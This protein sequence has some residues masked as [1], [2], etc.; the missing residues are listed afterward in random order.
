MWLMTSMWHVTGIRR[1]QEVSTMG[2]VEKW[3]PCLTEPVQA[4]GKQEGTFKIF[5]SGFGPIR[6]L[7]L[8][9]VCH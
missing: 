8:L 9:L 3:V 5:I 7:G 6:L 1:M 2:E 4:L